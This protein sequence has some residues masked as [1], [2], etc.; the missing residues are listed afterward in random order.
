MTNLRDY[1]LVGEDAVGSP[2]K[3]ESFQISNDADGFLQKPEEPRA[4]SAP[5]VLASHARDGLARVEAAGDM[6]AFATVRG[7]WKTLVI[8]PGI[9]HADA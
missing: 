2:A 8:G 7:G 3:L 9:E 1:L 5:V 4:F 6:P